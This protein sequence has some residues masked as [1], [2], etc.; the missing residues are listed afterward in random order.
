M[1]LNIKVSSSDWI[2]L[3]TRGYTSGMYLLNA[4]GAAIEYSTAATPV[5]G[6]TLVGSSAVLISGTYLWVRGSGDCELYTAS[7]WAAANT[8]TVPVMASTP[9]SGGIAGAAPALAVS[10]GSATPTPVRRG[11]SRMRAGS[12]Q[13]DGEV[14]VD[15]SSGPTT[16][17][18]T[19]QAG[20]ARWGLL[21]LPDG[22]R[23]WG[24]KL[25]TPFGAGNENYAEFTIP[26]RSISASDVFEVEFYSPNGSIP[27]LYVGGAGLSGGKYLI[28]RS[29]NPVGLISY[30]RRTGFYRM[31]IP[32]SKMSLTGGALVSDA[33]TKIRVATTNTGSRGRECWVTGQIRLNRREKPQ[34]VI[35]TDDGLIENNWLADQLAARGLKMTAYVIPA[36]IGVSAD[37]MTEAQLAQLA[38]KPNVQIANH[39]YSHT[40]ANG[41]PTGSIWGSTVT[42]ICAAQVVAVGALALNGSIGTALFDKPRHL[43][44]VTTSANNGVQVDIVGELDG[45]SR[46]E[47]IYLGEANGYPYPSSLVYDKVTSLTVSTPSPAVAA[48]NITVGTSCS[49]DEL[50]NDIKRGFEYLESR[51]FASTDQRHYCC[52]Q[53]LWNN[54]LMQAL[55]DLNVR[56]CR[57]TDITPFELSLEHDAYKL[58]ACAVEEALATNVQAYCELATLSGS[59]VN[60]YLHQIKIDN[61]APAAGGIRA[62]TLTPLLDQWA[63][64]VQSGQADSPTVS[65]M[66][67]KTFAI[68]I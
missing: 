20:S 16:A 59:S 43:T 39:S 26:S 54:T 66:Y 61:S 11:Q 30:A 56:T 21:T 28:W 19:V 4:V 57:L 8:K 67:A 9:S 41:G 58:P 13:S 55:E 7:E 38:A 10:A 6:T 24:V 44:F 36:N 5:P 17:L 12:L 31:R 27:R 45:V 18:A 15:L 33:V 53:G 3:R 29:V 51:G 46:S 64:Y 62:S 37:T 48:G 65:E 40:Y 34:V 35:T 23:R 25:T 52:P 47:T 2:D 32:V 42:G 68:E 49:Y 60:I 50:Y 22:R 63:N 14:L 1:A